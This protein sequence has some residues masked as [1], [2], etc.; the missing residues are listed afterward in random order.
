[1][2]EI[3]KVMLNTWEKNF[4]RRVYGWTSL[5]NQNYD[6]GALHKKIPDLVADTKRRLEWL[7]HV[8]GMDQ[9]RVT[10]NIFES[11]LEGNREGGRPRLRR[12]EM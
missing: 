12:L 8:I 10:T 4:L 2:T 7:G 6:L 9:T 11:E 1:M 5:G 3:N